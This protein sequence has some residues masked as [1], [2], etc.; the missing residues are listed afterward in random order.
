M[1]QALSVV[2]SLFVLLP[3]LHMRAEAVEKG[4]GDEENAAGGSGEYPG[5]LPDKEAI[6]QAVEDAVEEAE[7][8]ID[9]AI[10]DALEGAEPWN[11]KRRPAA[12]KKL[13]DIVLPG[14]P[15]REQCKAYLRELGEYTKNNRMFSDRDPEVDKLKALP[16]EHLDLIYGL[17]DSHF[18]LSIYAEYAVQDINPKTV[19]K[20]MVDHLKE[21]PGN[22]AYVVMF[23]WV[24]DAKPVIREEFATAKGAVSTPWYQAFVELAEPEDY[25]RLH[26]LAVGAYNAADFIEL[27]KALPDY[28]VDNTIDACWA[29]WPG[30]AGA[31][32]HFDS[33]YTYDDPH[34]E[35]AVH[36]AGIG[37]LDAL[38]L[39]IDRLE[40]NKPGRWGNNLTDINNIRL[41]VTRLI[42]YRGTNEDTKAW[43]KQNKDK[44]LFDH[45]KKRYVIGEDF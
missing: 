21:E 28:D 41:R 20:A 42:P 24:Q 3:A 6:K 11:K 9:Q 38:E 39:L 44:L 17:L 27:L 7:K 29:R 22:I 8:A 32:D 23:G 15:T 35:L 30:E 37:K 12:G 25:P 14:N 1:R 33:F 36:A 5:D 26:Q 45:L 18:G 16:P 13:D 34:A 4:S 2:V 43:F 10:E 31:E 40:K 19:R